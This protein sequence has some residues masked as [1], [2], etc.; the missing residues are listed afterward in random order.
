MSA[1]TF[2][3][4]MCEQLR[5]IGV[6]QDFRDFMHGTNNLIDTSNV[7]DWDEFTTIFRACI[8]ELETLLNEKAYDRSDDDLSNDSPEFYSWVCFPKGCLAFRR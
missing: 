4:R 5:R 2:I 3:K 7:D 6:E 1:S 8:D